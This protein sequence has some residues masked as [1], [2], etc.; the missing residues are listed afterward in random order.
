MAL[1]SQVYV[2]EFWSLEGIGVLYDTLVMAQLVHRNFENEVKNFGDTIHTRRPRMFTAKKV[3]AQAGTD[4]DVEI[5]VENP[6]AK[7][8]SV[9]LNN[10][11]YTAYMVEDRDKALSPFDLVSQYIVPALQPIAQMVDDDIMSEFVGADSTDVDGSAVTALADGTVGAGVA[12]D[13]DDIIAARLKLTQNKAP[14]SPRVLVLS[15]D[16]EADLLKVAN[17]V[18]AANAG[19]GGV[20]LRTANLGQKYGFN[21]FMSQN[22][23]VAIDTDD[24]PCSLAFHPNALALVTRPLQQVD[25]DLGVRS[26]S[27]A[28]DGIAVRTNLSYEGRKLGAVMT[29]D[30]IYGVQLLDSNL[31]CIINP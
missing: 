9:T 15:P 6:T 12:M 30:L 23:P 1:I 24:T 26:S 17:F 19:D 31:A 22:V 29:M 18:Q 25:S 27:L 28:M 13:A 14:Q 16:H 4:A 21:I 10:H 5:A 2:P 7:D 3:T 11:A 20:A 8:L